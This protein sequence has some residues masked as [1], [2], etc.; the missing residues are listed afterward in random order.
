MGGYRRQMLEHTAEGGTL[1]EEVISSIRN[2]HA[3]GT[4]NKLGAMYDVFNVR[5]MNL[6]IKS[7]VVLA[8]GLSIMFF[9]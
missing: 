7:G 3:F 1:A 2:A 8:C 9:S 6:G 4:Q 5:T